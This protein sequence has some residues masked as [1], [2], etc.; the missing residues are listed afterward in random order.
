MSRGRESQA[1]WDLG[2]NAERRMGEEGEDD[3]DTMTLMRRTTKKLEGGW[4]R[5]I[6]KE[7]ADASRRTWSSVETSRVGHDG[8]EG[9]LASR[10]FGLE[11]G[12]GSGGAVKKG[13]KLFP[14]CPK[15]VIFVKLTPCQ[16][17]ISILKFFLR[18][19]HRTFQAKH[20][21][22]LLTHVLG[23]AREAF[24]ALDLWAT[25]KRRKICTD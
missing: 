17:A 22:L 18:P 8:H 23:K 7:D 19:I 3:D 15:G 14:P 12:H 25:H 4:G 5:T 10:I 20:L 24:L 16:H 21:K 2:A 6:C 11:S 13:A 9:L 1:V